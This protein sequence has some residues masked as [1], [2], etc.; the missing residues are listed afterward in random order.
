MR[1]KIVPLFKI[2]NDRSDIEAISRVIKS[3]FFWATGKEIEEFEKKISKYI[4]I[5]YST[6]VNSGTSALIAALMAAGIGKDD[7]VIVPSFTFAATALSVSAVGAKPV[8]ADIEEMSCGLDHRDIKKKINNKTKAII[9]VHYA[10]YPCDIVAINKIARKHNLILIEDAAEAFG[11]KIADKMIGTLSDLSVFSFCQ[12]K[13][14]TTGEGGAVVSNNL[15]FQKSLKQIISHGKNIRGDFFDNKKPED[16]IRLGF[17]WRMAS[18]TAALGIS[19]LNKVEMMIKERIKIAK[20]YKQRLSKIPEISFLPGQEN[21]R[22]VFQMLPIRTKKRDKLMDYLNRSNIAS[23]ICF[24][25]IH[26][27][28]Y[29]NC[30]IKLPVTEKI[31]KEILTLPI[32]PKMLQEDLDF[33]TDKIIKF[34]K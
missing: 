10:G 32:F 5:K 24:L 8:F 21:S 18:M 4:G 30:D 13:I 26:K 34:Y 15:S 2:Y 19:Q 31:S 28:Y 29:Y 20:F 25:P 33:V 6:V 22:N 1:K 16:Y 27:C 14:I 11:A 3:G 7:E 9:A 23:R 12:N 17:N